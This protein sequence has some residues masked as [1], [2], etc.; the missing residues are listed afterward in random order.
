MIQDNN[1]H[2]VLISQVEGFS[3]LRLGIRII[4]VFLGIV[5]FTAAT[6]LPIYY[7]FKP[8]DTSCCPMTIPQG[9]TDTFMGVVYE[10]PVDAS[11]HLPCHYGYDQSG[12]IRR[13]PV[14]VDDDDEFQGLEAC[15]ADR[16]CYKIGNTSRGWYLNPSGSC[17]PCTQVLSMLLG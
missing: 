11:S 16:A 15:H 8:L 13:C 3:P 12:R 4:L 6:V 5:L 10:C 7:F 2:G 9:G 14:A 1:E 17:R